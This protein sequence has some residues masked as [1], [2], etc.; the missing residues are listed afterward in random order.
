MNP[1]IKSDEKE[2]CGKC[3]ALVK[4]YTTSGQLFVGAS[5]SYYD[6]SWHKYNFCPK[7]GEPVERERRFNFQNKTMETSIICGKVYDGA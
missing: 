3:G 1:V 5:E 6:Y 7:C 4:F 2:Y